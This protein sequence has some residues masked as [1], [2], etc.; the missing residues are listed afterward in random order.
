[1]ALFV[2]TVWSAMGTGEEQHVYY[3]R[4][5]LFCK[6]V[7]YMTSKNLDPSVV[8]NDRKFHS[9]ERKLR[10]YSDFAYWVSVWLPRIPVDIISC[11]LYAGIVYSCTQLRAG[12]AYFPTYLYFSLTANMSSFLLFSSVAAICPSLTS[13]LHIL[14]MLQMVFILL[15]GFPQYLPEMQDWVRWLTYGAVSRYVYQGI[16]MNEFQDNG[17]LPESHR[18]LVMLGF[19]GISVGGCAAMMLM[20]IG[21]GLGTLF[22]ALKYVDYERR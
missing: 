17:N 19:T 7:V 22:L 21:L 9:R 18:Y 20:F 12:A 8:I 10:N 4:L 2:G 5:S 16:V 3:D 6:S 11:L 14:P 13:A 1:M 15:S